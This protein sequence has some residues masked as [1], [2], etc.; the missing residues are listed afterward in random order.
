MPEEPKD[1]PPEVVHAWRKREVEVV[2]PLADALA[3][4][5]RRTRHTDSVRSLN[6]AGLRFRVS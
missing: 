3:S 2:A 1:V 4:A 5:W 6:A